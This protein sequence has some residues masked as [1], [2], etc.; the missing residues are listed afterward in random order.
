MSFHFFVNKNPRNALQFPTKTSS[1]HHINVSDLGFLMNTKSGLLQIFTGEGLSN[2]DSDLRF[3]RFLFVSEFSYD[4]RIG[5]EGTHEA[6]TSAFGGKLALNSPPYHAPFVERVFHSLAHT[7][8]ILR[9]INDSLTHYPD[10][11]TFYWTNHIFMA[12]EEWT[13]I[14]YKTFFL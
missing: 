7:I 1:G 13:W 6:A 11:S 4:R 10:V 2:A 12:I 3:S 8:S 9:L 14:G 5:K